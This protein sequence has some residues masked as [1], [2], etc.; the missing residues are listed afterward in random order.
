MISSQDVSVFGDLQ[1]K[2]HFAG[3]LSEKMKVA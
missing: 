1:T 2:K 3:R